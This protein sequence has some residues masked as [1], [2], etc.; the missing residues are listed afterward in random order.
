MRDDIQNC[1][2]EEDVPMNTDISEL[3]NSLKD[4][5]HKFQTLGG[6]L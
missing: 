1:P 2:Y 6:Y 4:L 5:A 3:K